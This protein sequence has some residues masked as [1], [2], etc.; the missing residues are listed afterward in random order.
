MNIINKPNC[1]AADRN[2]LTV[3]STN[4]K[5]TTIA[6]PMPKSQPLSKKKLFSPPVITTN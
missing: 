4:N 1:C 2:S 5:A 3:K 6:I